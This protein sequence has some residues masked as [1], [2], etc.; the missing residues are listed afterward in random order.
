MKELYMA[1]TSDKYEIPIAVE[2]SP[3]KLAERINIKE[4]A[5][6]TAIALKRSGRNRGI[7]FLKIEV[8]EDIND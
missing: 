1:V 8:E 5:I 2:E 6:L 3:K 4:S 7:K